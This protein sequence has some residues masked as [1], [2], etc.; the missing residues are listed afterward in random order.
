[1]I[2]Y[3]NNKINRKIYRIFYNVSFTQYIFKLYKN[4]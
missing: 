1:M 3:I 2:V 4:I